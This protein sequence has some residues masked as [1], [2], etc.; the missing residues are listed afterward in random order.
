M[1]CPIDGRTFESPKSFSNHMRIH[2]FGRERFLHKG[3][4][5]CEKNNQW[6]GDLVGVSAVHGWVKRRKPKPKFCVR[7]KIG[8]A[9]DLAN[10]S[11]QYKRDVSDYEW[12]CRRCH[13]DDDGRLENIHRGQK[14]EKHPNVKLTENDIFEI[15]KLHEEGIRTGEIARMF[16]VSYGHIW[17]VYTRAAWAHLKEGGR[18]GKVS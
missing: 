10:I 1:K 18:Y 12:L 3:I 9:Q 17:R 15:R 14:G 5:L 11:G 8:K 7:C 4:N 13:M 2:K 16:R 6:K